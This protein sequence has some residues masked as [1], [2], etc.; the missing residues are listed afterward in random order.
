MSV[1]LIKQKAKHRVLLFSVCRTKIMQVTPPLG[2]IHHLTVTLIFWLKISFPSGSFSVNQSSCSN[3]GKLI[4]HQPWKSRSLSSQA[5][6]QMSFK[7][8]MSFLDCSI[9][10]FLHILLKQGNTHLLHGNLLCQSVYPKN[11]VW[12]SCLQAKP[13]VWK[14]ININ[15]KTLLGN[16]NLFLGKGISWIIL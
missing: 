2:R 15:R 11:I 4:L 7:L 5:R 8:G 14:I 10:S 1:F 6:P 9:L 13:Y 16:H 12:G 3:Y